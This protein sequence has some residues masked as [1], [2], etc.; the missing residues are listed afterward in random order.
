MT[1]ELN[2]QARRLDSPSRFHLW[3]L[4]RSERVERARKFVPMN[5]CDVCG[6]I[7]FL[8]E[9]MAHECPMCK[10]PLCSN[11]LLRYFEG[12]ILQS[13]DMRRFHQYMNCESK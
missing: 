1:N 7:P 11:C 6:V 3:R 2:L 8:W 10:V 12:H 9:D 5:V 4:Y 13:W